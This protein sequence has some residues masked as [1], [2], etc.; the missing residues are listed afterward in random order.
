MIPWKVDTIIQSHF[1]YE[2]VGAQ[3][4][5]VTAKFTQL[6]QGLEPESKPRSVGLL[7]GCRIAWQ[8]NPWAV[9]LDCVCH[10]GE[11]PFLWVSV[12]LT[13]KLIPLHRD[14]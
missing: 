12:F 5:Y 6:G 8:L 9:E 7:L 2:A 14:S 1:T 13:I 4:N 3:G 11:A 10:L